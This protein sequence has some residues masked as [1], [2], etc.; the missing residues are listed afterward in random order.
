MARNKGRNRPDAAYQARGTHSQPDQ[1]IGNSKVRGRGATRKATLF[2]QPN[3]AAVKD[4][5]ESSKSSSSSSTSS[6]EDVL[7]TP[8]PKSSLEDG[9][10]K[11]KSILQPK[12]SKYS[13]KGTQRRGDMH[14]ADKSD[15][16]DANEEEDDESTSPLATAVARNTTTLTTR[17]QVPPKKYSSAIDD[18]ASH[19][20]YLPP[21]TEKKFLVSYALP[22]SKPQGPGDMWTC[23]FEGCLK[24]VHA[25]S[26]ED[27][28]VAIQEHF[29]DHATSAEEKIQ[30][31]MTESRPYLPVGYVPFVQRQTI[32]RQGFAKEQYSNL[33]AH[34]QA[35]QSNEPVEAT[36]GGAPSGRKFPRPIRRSP[37]FN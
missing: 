18:Y 25:A 7:E 27:G 31:A 2:N 29:K 3:S 37:F 12:G 19:H 30:L 15:S 20:T 22:S 34:L 24:R 33:V 26:T 32:L 21:V 36:H 35:H 10:H 28:K 13:K 17:T 1:A 8:S 6:E 14:I 9:S 16:E 5:I 11:R 4:P 23:T